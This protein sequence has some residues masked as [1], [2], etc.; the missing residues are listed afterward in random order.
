[1]VGW[2]NKCIWQNSSI[3]PLSIVFNS[4]PTFFTPTTF[5]FQLYW[6][7]N[8]KNV[9]ITFISIPIYLSI[10]V[11]FPCPFGSA[12]TSIQIQHTVI[13]DFKVFLSFKVGMVLC[14]AALVAHSLC[15]CLKLK[16]SIIIC[17][18]CTGDTSKR[19]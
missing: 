10:M 17:I 15:V 9:P 6:G 12:I 13:S 14:C 8:N 3:S 1:M 18:I 11:P 7:I 16:C 2:V 19:F 4:F 5:F